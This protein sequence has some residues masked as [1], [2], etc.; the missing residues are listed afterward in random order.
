MLQ[1]NNV[2]VVT[3]TPLG[4]TRS[5]TVPISEVSCSGSRIGN[6]NKTYIQCTALTNLRVTL[7]DEDEL[8]HTH[9]YINSINPRYLE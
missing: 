8:L 7:D 2:R 1:G 6:Y 9:S 5:L 4:G 3:H